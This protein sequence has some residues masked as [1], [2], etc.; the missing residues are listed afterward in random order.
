MV[1]VTQASKCPL[2]V[3]A[4]FGTCFAGAQGGRSVVLGDANW[5]RGSTSTGMLFAWGSAR[6]NE[7]SWYNLASFWNE[8]L[9]DSNLNK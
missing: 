7:P 1:E 5:P 3:N 2:Q 4:R 9:I 6:S 8:T